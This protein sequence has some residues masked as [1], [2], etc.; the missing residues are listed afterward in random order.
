MLFI[1]ALI[2]F[3]FIL[4]NLESILCVKFSLPCCREL[5]L[6]YLRLDL[7]CLFRFLSFYNN[8][9]T[10]VARN[11]IY[12]ICDLIFVYFNFNFLIA[13]IFIGVWHVAADCK[14]INCFN[15]TKLKQSHWSCCNSDKYLY[16]TF[17]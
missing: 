5:S 2:P 14:K 7:F 1:Y 9:Y 3:F 12:F 16:V 17:S 11:S 13:I 15:D 6:F 10:C 8:F 4:K